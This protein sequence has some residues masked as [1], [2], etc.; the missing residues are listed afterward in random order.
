LGIAQ[1]NYHL[2]N[3]PL[4]DRTVW[5]SWNMM[6]GNVAALLGSMLGP[7]VAGWTGMPVAF[8][9]LAGLRLVIAA[10]IWKRG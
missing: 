5:L 1:F 8:A 10:V 6:F 9:I 3:L 7:L 2:D 4:Q